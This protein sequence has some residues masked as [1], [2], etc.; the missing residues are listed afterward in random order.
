MQFIDTHKTSSFPTSDTEWLFVYNNIMSFLRAAIWHPFASS[1]LLV[2][3]GLSPLTRDIKFFVA[4]IMLLPGLII[5]WR[6]LQQWRLRYQFKNNSETVL[7]DDFFYTKTLFPITFS[8]MFPE[9]NHHLLTYEAP[10]FSC[11]QGTPTQRHPNDLQHQHQ[12]LRKS[13]V[14]PPIQCPNPHVCQ[15]GCVRDSSHTKFK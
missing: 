8:H 10:P 7:V 5:F 14:L 11:I 2:Q 15:R 13:Q 12:K 4:F 3:Q 1:H 9:I 6:F